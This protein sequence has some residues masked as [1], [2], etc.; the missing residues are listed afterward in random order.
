MLQRQVARVRHVMGF[1]NGLFSLKNVAYYDYF[2]EDM[3]LKVNSIDTS[4]S[5]TSLTNNFST[6]YSGLS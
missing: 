1:G 3:E 5:T 6:N 2:V 4:E